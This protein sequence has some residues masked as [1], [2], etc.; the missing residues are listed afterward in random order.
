MSSLNVQVCPHDTATNPDRWFRFVQYCAQKMDCHPHFEIALD[1]ADFHAS[2]DKADIVYANPSD[3]LTLLDKGLKVLVHPSNLHD[4]VVFLANLEVADPTLEALQGVQIASVESLQ[5]TK[6]AL[7]ILKERGVA[8]SGIANYESWT[9]VV[10]SLWRGDHQFGLIYKDTY[11]ELSDQG[12]GMVQ[13]FYTSN[14]RTAFHNILV[15]REAADKQAGIEQVLLGMHTDEKGQEVLR[16]L[17]IEQWVPT[18]P[19]ELARI[20]HI[21][22]TY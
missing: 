18:T 21:M 4:E 8:P 1:F 13:A 22:E 19:E 9:A 20:R 15:G 16:D 5:P 10:S 3:T 6:L 12:K 2:L 11:D 7:H 14:E 17:N